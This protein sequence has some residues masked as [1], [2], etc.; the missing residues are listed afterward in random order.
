MQRLNELLFIKE[1][2]N[3]YERILFLLFR[4]TFLKVYD[5]GRITGVNKTLE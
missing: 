2:L 1:K 5:I 4:K 3:T